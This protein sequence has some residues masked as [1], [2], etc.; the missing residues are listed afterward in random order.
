MKEIGSEFWDIPI[1]EKENSLFGDLV[2]WY[3]SG[4][5]ALSAIIRDIQGCK[6][7]SMP[8]WCCDSMIKPFI[9]AG[10]EVRFYPVYWDDRL[11][12]EL[13]FDSDILFIMD[14]FGYSGDA[15][16]ISGYH[17][18][19]IRDITHSLFS[20]FPKDADYYFG[21]L[22]KWCGAWTG[23]FAWT[24]DGQKLPEGCCC[25][26]HYTVLRKKA[27][28]L[29][30][31]YITGPFVYD[32]NEGK[33]YLNVFSEAEDLLEDLD[34]MAA[35]E[36]DI[37]LASVM[38]AEF[39]RRRRKSNGRILREAFPDLIM[40]SEE[41]DEECPMFIPILV[42]GHKRDELRR[43]LIADNI[44]CPI[45]WPVSQYHVLDEKTRAIYE[46]ELSL[47]CDQRYNEDDMNRI[48]DAIRLFLKEN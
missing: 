33:E 23:G 1:A 3:V 18:V 34:I 45:H 14:Y 5:S 41:A 32:G 35:N 20:D 29:K 6:T 15:T 17:G 12:R 40:F 16:D 46:N 43:S 10:I 13:S 25:D 19:V 38:D 21:S 39:I 4:R 27:M 36:R 44:F 7:V 37:K 26:D 47:V 31:A 30:E 48:A 28:R 42:P 9:D 24:K 11:I 2:Q 8:S 22:R